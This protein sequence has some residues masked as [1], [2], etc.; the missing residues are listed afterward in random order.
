MTL[1]R[2]AAVVA[3]LAALVFTP[4]STGSALG[5][6]RV[7]IIL[8]TPGERPFAVADVQD[9]ARAAADFY[10]RSSFGKLDLHFDVTPWLTAFPADPGCVFTS[11]RTLDQLMQPARLA[12]ERAGYAPSGY[13]RLVY[14]VAGS[15]CA[16]YG[17]TIGREVTLMRIPTFQLLVHELGHTF[18]LAHAQSSQCAVNCTVTD[19]GD[20]YTPMGTGERLLDFTVYEK[21]LLGWL[22]QQRRATTSG[23]YTLEPASVAGDK[24]HAL[25][26]DTPIGQWWVEYRAAP[27]RGLLLRFVD[28]Q[29]PVASPFAEPTVLMLDP[30]HRGRNW[31]ARN[32]LYKSKYFSL[33][34]VHAGTTSARVR[35][36]LAVP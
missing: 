11:Q 15:H 7:L 24:L 31:I 10:R 20:P 30:M 33:R 5:N 26:V 18:G 3:L 8:A 34:L 14:V 27:F 28:V 32:E 2:L 16:F 22:P 21:V 4:S 9:V 17:M 25:V 1:G 35:L 36:R 19:P 13:S 23:M 12:A 29:H 6:Q